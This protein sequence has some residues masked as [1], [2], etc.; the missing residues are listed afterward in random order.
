V[1]G[2]INT[3]S[4]RTVDMANTSLA[5]LCKRLFED[6]YTHAGF[7]TSKS[8]TKFWGDGA[9]PGNGDKPNAMYFSKLYLNEI[10]DE[11]TDEVKGKECVPEWYTWVKAEDFYV[12]SYGQRDIM[13]IKVNGKSRDVIDDS[14][15]AFTN[16]TYSS[17]TDFVGRT[18]TNWNSIHADGYNGAVIDEPHDKCWGRNASWDVAT[19]VIWNKKCTLL[20]NG[21]MVFK[22]SGNSYEYASVPFSVEEYMA[23][24]ET[25]PSGLASAL[26][27]LHERIVRLIT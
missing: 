23:S 10:Y 17:G 15:G 19:A 27:T 25:E 13:F 11:D 8:L 3:S 16:R 6:G 5:E 2:S 14:E 7:L 20:K 1:G 4:I 21:A 12:D 24:D 26:Q 22:A 18:R 9:E